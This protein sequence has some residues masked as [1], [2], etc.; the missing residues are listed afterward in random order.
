MTYFY[1]LRLDSFSISR[2]VPKWAPH[3]QSFVD[4]SGLAPPSEVCRTHQLRTLPRSAIPP[5]KP[6]LV[7]DKVV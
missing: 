1:A 5:D 4:F 7:A 6:D 2:G 3:A